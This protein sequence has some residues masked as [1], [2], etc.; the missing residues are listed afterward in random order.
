MLV[1]KIC[2]RE[3]VF[4]EPDTSVAEAARLM[5][6]HHVGGL[7]V[8]QEK[9]GKRVPVGII[10]DRDLVIE[11]I[12]AGVDMREITVGDIM[13]DQLVTAREGDDL[14]ETLKMMRARGIRRLPV[15]DDDGV[16]AGILTVDDLIDLF[17]EQIADL[18]R[19]IAFEQKREQ[20]RRR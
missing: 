3:V 9:S 12:A 20:E 2:N 10:T 15:I 16:L 4:V 11:V 17:A 19:L 8:V 5:R 1:G 6:E 18:A 14:L 7:V 13:S